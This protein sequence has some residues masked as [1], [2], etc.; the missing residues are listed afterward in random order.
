MRMIK[1]KG[2]SISLDEDGYLLNRDDW[3]EDLGRYLCESDGIALTDR[4]WEIILFMRTYNLQY[5]MN[6]MPRII[7]KEL[8]RRSPENKYNVRYLY[9][10]FPDTPTHRLCRYAG[11]PQPLGCG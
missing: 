10:L 8:N 6:P 3:T 7:I 4:H 1:F 11:I 9:E 2:E 5:K